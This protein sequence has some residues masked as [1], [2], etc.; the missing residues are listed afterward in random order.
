MLN[1][2]GLVERTH[3]VSLDVNASRV[4]KFGGA[5]QIQSV[6][7]NLKIIQRGTRLEHFEIVPAYEMSVQQFQ[8]LLN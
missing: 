5:Y 3:G 1:A 7:N 8:D 4:S 6:P 2:D